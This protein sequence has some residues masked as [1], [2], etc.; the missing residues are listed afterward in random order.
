MERNHLQLRWLTLGYIFQQLS[1]GL[2]SV[3]RYQTHLLFEIIELIRSD[4]SSQWVS[5]VLLLVDLSKVDF[6][7]IL[8]NKVI[9]M[10]KVFDSQMEHWFFSLSYGSNAT[11]NTERLNNQW[12][13]P[14]QA[15][16]RTF[17][18]K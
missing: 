8:S 16:K 17:I 15:C 14:L 7:L 4:C 9:A 2:K 6:I 11:V 5:Q 3:N 13:V 18:I 10:Q 1:L 12:R